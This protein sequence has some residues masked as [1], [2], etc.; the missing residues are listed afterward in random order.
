MSICSNENWTHQ[1]TQWLLIFKPWH[2]RKWMDGCALGFMLQENKIEMTLP[3]FSYKIYL[4]EILCQSCAW[5]AF[6]LDKLKKKS[7]IHRGHHFRINLYVYGI[8]FNVS[9]IVSELMVYAQTRL[10]IILN[11]WYLFF[12]LLNQFNC[13]TTNLE[14]V[15]KLHSTQFCALDACFETSYTSFKRWTQSL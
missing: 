14:I 2:N 7:A 8:K 11:I 6:L 15:K 5:E 10:E 13:N 9:Q 12:E 1:K 4:H 3:A